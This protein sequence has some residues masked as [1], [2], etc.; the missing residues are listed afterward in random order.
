M[1]NQKVCLKPS[2][3]LEPLFNQ[4]YA[5]PY[6][7]PPASAAMYIANAHV[8]I[9]QSFV[10]APQV[11]IAALKNPGMLGGPFINY[12]VSKVGEIKQLADKTT[13]ENAH[14]VKF[15]EAIKTLD[16]TLMAEATGFSLEGFYQK[17][18]EVLRGYVE[19]VYDL[20]NNPSIRFIEGLLYKS[21]YY[22]PGSQS[23]MLSQVDSDG[24]SFVF[25]TPR[26]KS[27]GRLYLDIPFEHAG[28]DE[29]FKME[30]EPQ[31]YDYIREM[32]NISEADNQQFSSFF[33][34][35][36]PQKA[37]RY[38]GEGVRIRYLGHA[39]VLIETR[40]VSILVDPVISSKSA[41]GIDRFTYGDLPE[42]LDYVLITH[43]HQDHVM[44]ESLLHLR[45]KIKKL[46]VPQS[47]GGDRMDP[48]LKLLLK[49]V[50]FTNVYDL[51]EMESIEIADG[52]ITGLPFLGEHVETVRT[53]T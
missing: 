35:E 41:S 27:D 4:W 47:V 34:E 2:T 43:T 29:L 48:S 30:F 21:K 49:T 13:S 24:R 1:N 16:E 40:D 14:M 51:E 33:T 10:S 3:L 44:F 8:K 32:L 36:V 7:I 39:C 12:D 50:G 42:T 20:Q 5:W 22:N 9:M 17:T 31:P 25:S 52:I 37:R 53:L 6:L 15:A 11:H 45:H 19:L 26:L 23:V 46:I 18:P 28:L 38:D